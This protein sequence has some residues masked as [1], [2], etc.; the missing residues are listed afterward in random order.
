MIIVRPTDS[1]T[2][3]DP[4]TPVHYEQPDRTLLCQWPVGWITKKTANP[5]QVNCLRCWTLLQAVA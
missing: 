3:S 5:R 2:A 1:P 4:V